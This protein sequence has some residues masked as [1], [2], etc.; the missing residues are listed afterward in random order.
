MISASKHSRYDQ[1]F[2][3]L[4]IDEFA[5]GRAIDDCVSAVSVFRTYEQAVSEVE[6]LGD[7]RSADRSR[8]I[9][10]TSR[11]KGEPSSGG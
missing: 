1:L 7:L 5:E 4:R 11:L 10:L 6:R 8:Y 3:I 2:V 9:V